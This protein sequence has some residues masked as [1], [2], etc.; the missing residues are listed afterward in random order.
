MPAADAG[1]GFEGD[2]NAGLERRGGFSSRQRG[3]GERPRAFAARAREGE[4]E[5]EG[6]G[7][8]KGEGGTQF[9]RIVIYNI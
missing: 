2:V 5:G 9:S 1:G 6:R 4:G 8:G 7:R 3:G